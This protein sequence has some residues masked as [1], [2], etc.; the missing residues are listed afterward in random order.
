MKQTN[1]PF[2]R[3]LQLYNDGFRQTHD[4]TCGPAS[5]ALASIG[6]GLK[7]KQ[8][9]EWINRDHA[10]WMPVD[11]FLERG[12]ALHELQFIS[13]LIY[14]QDID[15]STR[16]SYPE[17]LSLFLSDVK[18]SFHNMDSVIIV[19]Y[20]QDDFIANKSSP[21]G[22]PHYSPVVNLSWEKNE[23]MIADID[24]EI[25][26]PYWVKIE[27]IFQSMSHCNPAFNIPRGWLVLRKRH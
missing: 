22:N 13:Q 18:C 25:Q 21:S 16:R 5:I 3:I 24:P 12:M 9:S 27:N 15:I 19:N 11:Q 2:H 7:I 6:L 17:N 8:E 26:A 23:I 1:N 4:A 14:G 20:Q 10:R